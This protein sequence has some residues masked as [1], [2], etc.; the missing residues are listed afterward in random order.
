MVNLQAAFAPSSSTPSAPIRKSFAVVGGGS[1]G[2]AALRVLLELQVASNPWDVVL[3]E[4]RRDVGGV[5]LP[6]NHKPDP[7]SIPETP[8]YPL[9]HTNTPVPSMTYP[10]FHIRPYHRRYADHFNITPWIQFNRRHWDLNGH[11]IVATG[12]NHYPHIPVWKGQDAW[13]AK[14]A[15]RQSNP[16][17]TRTK[18]ERLDIVTQVSLHAAKTYLSSRSPVSWEPE[19]PITYKG[20]IANFTE[21][22]IWFSDG[23]FVDADVVIL[24]TGYENLFP[25]LEAGGIIRTD[26]SARR[27]SDDNGILQTNTR[28]VFPLH[29]HIVSLSSRLPVTALAFI[30]LPVFV[31]NCPSDRIQALYAVHTMSNSSLLP[32]REV[33]LTQLDARENWIRA[34]G[35]D[36]YRLGHRQ[37]MPG[38]HDYQDG[39][40]RHLQ[41]HG[42]V[43]DDGAPYVEAW[44]R[45]TVSIGAVLKRGWTR[46]ERLGTQ[47]EWLAGVETE[48]EW[49]DLQ[50]R[51]ARWQTEWEEEQGIFLRKEQS[52]F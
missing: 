46:I 49:A 21:N 28:Y 16:E 26:P 35:E 33:L 27:A 22:V 48:E 30:G 37:L 18:P 15:Q 31:A 4:Q 20:D 11:L 50:D 6:D 32:S 43:P 34:Q 44:R 52:L 51:I 42:A 39:L 9:L 40:W 24:G 12:N 17:N 7:P 2:L 45:H 25:F 47:Q 13:L 29:E 14:D 1:S 38:G 41:R 8:L 19:G 5:W 23:T 36:P 10:G 3:L